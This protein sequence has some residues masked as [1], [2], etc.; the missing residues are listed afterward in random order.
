MPD[1]V[2]KSLTFIDLTA[3]TARLSKLRRTKEEVITIHT[4]T[5]GTQS[6]LEQVQKT[7]T[8]HQCREE[9]KSS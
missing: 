2:S 9:R 5:N 8:Q 3:M 4:D 6:L 7:E 1:L